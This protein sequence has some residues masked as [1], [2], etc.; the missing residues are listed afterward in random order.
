MNVA[1]LPELPDYEGPAS[2]PCGGAGV[3]GLH[4]GGAAAAEGTTGVLQQQSPNS[5]RMWSDVALQSPPQRRQQQQQQEQT[6]Q[7][8]EQQ[9]E[10][11]QG[12]GPSTAAAAVPE[13]RRVMFAESA[14][15]VADTQAQADK[16]EAP[17]PARKRIRFA[18]DEAA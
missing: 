6:E 17:K 10:Q 16:S 14:A 12:A 11:Q 9:T 5:T 4:G 8:Q 15:D 3:G 13:G 2:L 18:D 1:E 7:Q